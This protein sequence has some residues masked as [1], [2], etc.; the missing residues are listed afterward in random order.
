MTRMIREIDLHIVV[1]GLVVS[2][3]F[4]GIVSTITFV[5]TSP[6]L[7]RTLAIGIVPLLIF[8][9]PA[10]LIQTLDRR[11]RGDLALRY[12]ITN[13]LLAISFGLICGLWLYAILPGEIPA[14]VSVAIP[15]P[16]FL[17]S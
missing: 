15:P 4:I 12:F 14:Q 7:L 1:I 11:W 16:A 3:L 8:L 10:I 5:P 13:N 9:E 2:T 6:H 17:P